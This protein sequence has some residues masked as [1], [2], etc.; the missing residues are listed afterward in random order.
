MNWGV[1]GYGEI[2]P[3]FIDGLNAIPKSKL[4]GIASITSYEFLQSKGIYENVKLYNN[5]TELI[6]NSDVNVIY[7]STTNNMHFENASEVILHGKHLICEKPLTPNLQKT[8][9]LIEKANKNAVFFMEGMWTRFLP[10]YQKFIN[11]LRNGAIGTPKLLKVDFGFHNSWPKNRRLLNPVLYGGTLLDNADYNIF[12]SQD[13]FGVYPEQIAA[14]ATYAETGVEDACSIIL[15]YP[16]GGM[17][18]L[19]SSFHCKTK[20]EAIV[21]GEKGYIELIEYWHGSKVLIN[22]NSSIHQ[23][24]YP[25]R[26]NGFE[27][28]IEAVERSINQGRIENEILPHSASIE[29][30]GIIDEIKLL[31]RK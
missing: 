29:V 14:Q 23:Y 17:A 3:S 16:S 9:E 30:A 7:I 11:L 5:Y 22:S 28:E 18:Q 10:S 1:I 20:Q 8:K 21:Y 15:K 26:V 6:K 2:A 13:V 24:E 19:F 31:I 27:Y 4:I 25:H 12:L